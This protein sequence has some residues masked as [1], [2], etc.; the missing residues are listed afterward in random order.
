MNNIK[1]EKTPDLI[2]NEEKI[3]II[4]RQTDLSESDCR[5]KFESNNPI[6]R[7]WKKVDGWDI[8]Y[9]EMESMWKNEI[10]MEYPIIK[11][12]DIEFYS[13]KECAEHFGVS[14]ERVRQKL[15]DTK[16]SDWIYL[17]K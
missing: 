6:Y 11:C 2:S 17:Y 14:S 5:N 10:V 16:Y 15:K 4:M 9:D 8:T 13:L 3:E 7:H 1:V 12:D